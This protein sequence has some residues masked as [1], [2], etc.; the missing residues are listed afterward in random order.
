MQGHNGYALEVEDD[1]LTLKEVLVKYFGYKTLFF[2]SKTPLQNMENGL[3]NNYHPKHLIS[4]NQ[5]NLDLLF[6]LLSS[7]FEGFF[8]LN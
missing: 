8:Y 5:E 1:Y 4:E 6:K 2:I 3:D 7:D